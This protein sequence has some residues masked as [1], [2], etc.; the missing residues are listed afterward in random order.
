MTTATDTQDPSTA[1]PVEDVATTLQFIGLDGLPI[2]GLAVRITIDGQSTDYQTDDKGFTPP[3]LAPPGKEVEV[4]VRR[5]DGSYKHIDQC[6]TPATPSNWTYI[7]PSMVFEVTTELHQGQPGQAESHIPQWSE[8]DMGVL[9]Q[10]S[11]PEPAVSDTYREE[12]RNHPKPT[13]TPPAPTAKPGKTKPLA[14]QQQPNPARATAPKT[15]AKA[16]LNKGRDAQGNPLMVYAEKV[17]DWWGSWSFAWPTSAHAH[18]KPLGAGGHKAVAYMGEMQKQVQALIDTA[19]ALTK[20]EISGSTAT[21]LAQARNGSKKL[22]EYKTK[23]SKDPKG[24]CYKYVKVALVQA[25]VVDDAAQGESASGAGP[26]LLKLGFRDVT[27]EL[28]D[29][30]WAAAGDVIVYAWSD[31]AW[32]SR[33]AKKKAPTMPNHGHIDIRSYATYISDFIPESGRPNWMDYTNIRIYRKVFD[34][35]PTIYIKAFLHCLR[36]FECTEEPDDSKRYNMLNTALPSNPNSRRF[37]SYKTH[38]WHEAVKVFASNNSK[39]AAGAYQ[40]QQATWQETIAKGL[41]DLTARDD[42]FSAAVQ[43]RVAVF[44]LEN[45]KALPLIR[46]NRI[47]D[48]IA[49]LQKTWTSLPGAG[50]NAKRKAPDGRPMD[51]AYFMSQFNKYVTE[52][53]A[54]EN[55]K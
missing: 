2:A 44:I 10:A 14:T 41:T 27:S 9:E 15:G 25:H 19:T 18:G 8:A 33:K 22:E 55:V 46:T 53:K 37:S 11:T 26:E 1:T 7:S 3:L 30:R 29:A 43:D 17:K 45:K 32:E 54:K 4:E 36:D 20:H 35:M 42:L 40:I 34:P 49:V 21:Y 47:G 52:E 6:T 5:M 12:G 39:S 48:A 51:M 50:E 16:P 31:R 23:P 24:W 38:P 13:T 28:P